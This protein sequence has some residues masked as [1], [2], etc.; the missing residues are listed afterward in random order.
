MQSYSGFSKE[1][2]KVFLEYLEE[3]AGVVEAQKNHEQLFLFPDVWKSQRIKSQSGASQLVGDLF[4][5]CTQEFSG[6]KRI[7]QDSS[8]GGHL[9]DLFKGANLYESKAAQNR[10]YFKVSYSQLVHYHQN[11]FAVT[12]FLWS[13]SSVALVSE[14]RTRGKIVE[15][16]T[17]G[18]D[19][20]DLIPCSILFRASEL[21][22]DSHLRVRKYESWNGYHCL[23]VG[24]PYLRKLRANP[25]GALQDLLLD[26]SKYRVETGRRRLT[27]NYMGEEIVTNQ[28]PYMKIIEVGGE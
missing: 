1:C 5:I 14:L 19:H 7:H 4:E 23:Q 2:D 8:S 28:F 13:Y 20:V 26:P 9:P 27:L 11:P 24:R 12:Y 17:R 3:Q 10:H 21:Q 15:T 18:I 16:I 25:S 22:P 6:A